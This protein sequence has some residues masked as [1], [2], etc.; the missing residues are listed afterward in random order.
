MNHLLSIISFIKN[1]FSFKTGGN[2]CFN[3]SAEEIFM[4]FKDKRR[5]SVPIYSYLLVWHI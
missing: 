2:I 3:L 4:I 5:M 1:E